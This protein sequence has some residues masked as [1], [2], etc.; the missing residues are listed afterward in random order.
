MLKED[1][2]V[3]VEAIKSMINSDPVVR[4]QERLMAVEARNVASVQVDA[5]MAEEAGKIA[6]EYGSN[7]TEAGATLQATQAGLVA[8]GW[9]H[10]SPPRYF[11][12]RQTHSVDDSRC[13]N[14]VT[15]LTPPGSECNPGRRRLRW[16][17]WRRR[18]R[19]C[20]RR[21]RR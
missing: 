11:V 9:W 5:A 13:S 12:R 10:F 17:N 7:L 1:L 4:E 14:H 3:D 18:A 16:R 15:N 8:L 20:L 6:R 2:G 19:R 21:R